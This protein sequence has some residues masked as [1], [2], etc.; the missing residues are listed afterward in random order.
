MS[1]RTRLSR[2]LGLEHSIV[3]GPMAGGPTTT[4]GLDLLAAV[5]DVGPMVS[6]VSRVKVSKLVARDFDLQAS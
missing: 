6:G 5:L 4:Q 2:T 1:L 3:Q